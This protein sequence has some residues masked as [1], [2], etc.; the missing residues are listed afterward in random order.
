MTAGSAAAD[1]WQ[2]SQARSRGCMCKVQLHNCRNQLLQL[3]RRTPVGRGS[4]TKLLPPST[5][6]LQ[7]VRIGPVRVTSSEEVVQIFANIK[8]AGGTRLKWYM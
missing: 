1:S 6:P 2:R 8:E 4:H 5:K 3:R 7:A